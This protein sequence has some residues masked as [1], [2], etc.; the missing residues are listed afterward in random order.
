MAYYGIL[1]HCIL[2][3]TSAGLWVTAFANRVSTTRRLQY[4]LCLACAMTLI[5]RTPKDQLWE[6]NFT[7]DTKNPV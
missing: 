2:S 4:K 3:S 6:G 1:Y 5:L 7:V